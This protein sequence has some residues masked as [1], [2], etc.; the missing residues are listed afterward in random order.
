LGVDEQAEYAGLD[1]A[2][3]RIPAEPESRL[4]T[5]LGNTLRAAESWPRDKYGLDTVVIWPRMWLVLSDDAREEI[6]NARQQLDQSITVWV[7]GLLLSVWVALTWWALLAAVVV[8]AFAYWRAITAAE[9]Y[10]DLVEA[11][12][13]LQR[14]ELYSQLRF[15]APTT[16]DKEVEVGEALTRY[17]WRGEGKITFTESEGDS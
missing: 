17:L 4:P 12:F 16:S 14:H 9:I 2:L 10:G 13:D 15:P 11:A 7:W 3:R 5:K 1:V 8:L 6:T